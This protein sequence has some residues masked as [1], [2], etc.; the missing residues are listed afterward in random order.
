MTHTYQLFLLFAPRGIHLLLLLLLG[1]LSI[2]SLHKRK[3]LKYASTHTK[4]TQTRS[5]QVTYVHNTTTAAVSTN[6]S[7]RTR[8]H[9]Y[10]R[11]H[12]RDNFRRAMNKS[13]P[14]AARCGVAPLLRLPLL[15]PLLLPPASS[16][17]VSVASKARQS[18]MNACHIQCTHIHQHTSTR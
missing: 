10:M 16:E 17:N 13:I 11:T 3:K 9:M 6:G 15:P 8:M 7:A 1:G 14:V 5:N 2:C 12:E 4:A 18:Q